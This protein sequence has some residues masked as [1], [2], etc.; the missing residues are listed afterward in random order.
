MLTLAAKISFLD[1]LLCF[2]YSFYC[3]GDE[4]K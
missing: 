3:A 1:A 4:A 2:F